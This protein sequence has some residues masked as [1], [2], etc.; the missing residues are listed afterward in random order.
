MDLDQVQQPVKLMVVAV[1][2]PTS[3][4]GLNR[5]QG[6]DQV[7]TIKRTWTRCGSQCAALRAARALLAGSAAGSTLISGGAGQAEQPVLVLLP[8]SCL[9]LVAAWSQSPALRLCAPCQH[10]GRR[11][12]GR[13]G[14]TMAVT[15]AGRLGK[16]VCSEALVS[17]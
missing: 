12:G 10:V 16:A 1:C 15:D 5:C 13:Q 11:Q 7:P 3:G 8:P 14:G 6:L 4:Q 17:S 2:C 9:P